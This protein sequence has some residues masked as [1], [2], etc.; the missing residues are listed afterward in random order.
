MMIEMEDRGSFV[1]SRLSEM[2]SIG[3]KDYD[4]EVEIEQYDR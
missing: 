4:R 2:G 3:Q 1:D